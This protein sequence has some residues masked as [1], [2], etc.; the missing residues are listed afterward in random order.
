MCSLQ[1]SHYHVVWEINVL[2][3]VSSSSLFL[4][5]CV[6]IFFISVMVENGVQMSQLALIHLLRLLSDYQRIIHAVQLI[7]FRH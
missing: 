3:N 7:I 6:F 2:F 5:W 1:M 4:I